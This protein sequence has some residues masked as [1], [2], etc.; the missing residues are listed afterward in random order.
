[1]IE[2]DLKKK[3]IASALAGGILFSTAF[4]FGVIYQSPAKTDKIY[5][6]ALDDFNNGNYQNSYYLFSK[7][8]RAHV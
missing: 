7:I 3:V 5:S 8:G 4:Y 1:M 2:W 6:A